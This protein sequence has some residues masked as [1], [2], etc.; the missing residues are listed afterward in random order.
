MVSLFP[1]YLQN[2]SKSWKRIPL[3]EPPHLISQIIRRPRQPNNEDSLDR[4]SDRS[5]G[6]HLHNTGRFVLR[7]K[8][9]EVEPHRS[10]IAGN[11]N[12]AGRGRNAKNLRVRSALRNHP[13]STSEIDGRLPAPQSP[14]DV[15]VEVGVSLKGDLQAR[16]EDRSLLTRSN[17][18]IMS[19]GIGC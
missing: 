10:E 14:S 7:H 9:P 11:K 4:R 13:A 1:I 19:A 5:R 8:I 17:R 16:L 18:S 3:W 6:R 15:R 2:A 12:P